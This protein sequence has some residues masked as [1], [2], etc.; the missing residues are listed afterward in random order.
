MALKQTLYSMVI[1]AQRT[2]AIQEIR[3][4]RG[5]IVSVQVTPATTRLRLWRTGS[6]P[7]ISEWRTVL[8]AWPYPVRLDEP[9][10]VDER[11]MHGLSGSWSTPR[12]SAEQL[13]LTEAS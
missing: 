1:S 5:L 8:N 6:R 12:Q 10:D 2:R 11:G 9:A 3:L 13:P 7:S 4:Q